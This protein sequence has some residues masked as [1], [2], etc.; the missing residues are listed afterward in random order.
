MFRKWFYNAKQALSE[1]PVIR[2]FLP[3]FD[4]HKT[5]SFGITSDGYQS[6]CIIQGDTVGYY[7]IRTSY[8]HEHIVL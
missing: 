1:K 8:N 6:K 4:S 2:I 5:I 7:K 3:Q